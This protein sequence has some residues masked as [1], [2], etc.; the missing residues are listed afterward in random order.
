MAAV[1][2]WRWSVQRSP[3]T[4]AALDYDWYEELARHRHQPYPSPWA[5]S[6]DATVA[7]T[8][9][10]DGLAYASPEEKQS[11][12]V[13]LSFVPHRI[14][15]V[16]TPATGQGPSLDIVSP[17]DSIHYG[18]VFDSGVAGERVQVRLRG[19]Y[20]SMPVAELDDFLA[21]RTLPGSATD[22]D[23]ETIRSAWSDMEA[24]RALD[25]DIFLTAQ[26]SLVRYRQSVG[27]Q[28]R[29]WILTIDEVLEYFETIAKGEGDYF[30]NSV[31]T[32]DRW[33]YYD[34]R[35]KQLVRTRDRVWQA[36]G[37]WDDPARNDVRDYLLSLRTRLHYLLEARDRIGYL[38][39]TSAGLNANDAVLYHL[40]YFFLLTTAIFDNLA[41][42]LRHRDNLNLD[43]RQVGLLH[44]DF[45]KRI[46]RSFDQFIALRES[47]LY[48]FYDTRHAVA[49]RLVMWGIGFQ[50]RETA[51]GS[52]L[53]EITDALASAVE[54]IDP[55][56]SNKPYSE[57]GLARVGPACLLEPYR[58]TTS[59]L[60]EVLRLVEDFF[61]LLLADETIGWDVPAESEEA[62]DPVRKLTIPFFRPIV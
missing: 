6:Q 35:T 21:R 13:L 18:D 15:A 57:W 38:Y 50:D 9:H 4:A 61:G 16:C 58:F 7:V 55:A 19:T 17:L 37:R 48:V 28:L 46:S 44:K 51:A 10:S 24:H 23:I 30:L 27:A 12:K 34:E 5:R 2:S 40:N 25:R 52:N 8:V 39:Y 32:T 26:P 53:V 45:R 1:D 47:L 14:D 42:I 56:L 62:P 22:Q 60:K 54:A 43:K 49:H 20:T 36:V 11:L 59:A 31:V 33:T 41:W 29:I 3:E